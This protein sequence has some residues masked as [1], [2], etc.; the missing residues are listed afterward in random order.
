MSSAPAIARIRD[1]DNGASAAAEDTLPDEQILFS[2]PQGPAPPIWESSLKLQHTFSQLADRLASETVV[3]F[4]PLAQPVSVSDPP[5]FVSSALSNVGAILKSDVYTRFGPSSGAGRFCVNDNVLLLVIAAFDEM[6]LRTCSTNMYLAR[7]QKALAEANDASTFAALIDEAQTANDSGFSVALFLSVV[8][9]SSDGSIPLVLARMPEWWALLKKYE[10]VRECNVVDISI[11][12]STVVTMKTPGV[13]GQ[14]NA[15][16]L[17]RIVFHPLPT[18]THANVSCSPGTSALKVIAC[19]ATRSVA[20]ATRFNAKWS[21]HISDKSGRSF[22]TS[23]SGHGHNIASSLSLSP[24][25]GRNV[26]MVCGE[27]DGT[28]TI[29]SSAVLK[30]YDDWSYV[31]SK[32]SSLSA[33]AGLRS[34]L[35]ESCESHDPAAAFLL[36]TGSCASTA[37]AFSGE[38]LGP[39]LAICRATGA[40]MHWAPLL[41]NLIRA[42]SHLSGDVRA[43]CRAVAQRWLLNWRPVLQGDANAA[44]RDRLSDICD[45]VVDSLSTGSL[46][47]SKVL[48]SLFKLLENGTT[49]E[50]LRQAIGRSDS[51]CL[52]LSHG[53]ESLSSVPIS[54]AVTALYPLLASGDLLAPFSGGPHGLLSQ[55]KESILSTLRESV[56]THDKYSNRARVLELMGQLGD[57]SKCLVS[58][59]LPSSFWVT[60]AAETRSSISHPVAFNCLRSTRAGLR[61]SQSLGGTLV[62]SARMGDFDMRAACPWRIGACAADTIRYMEVTLLSEG[63]DKIVVGLS[64][65]QGCTSTFS[66]ATGTAHAIV[67]NDAESQFAVGCGDILG[68]GV[69]LEHFVF[70]TINGSIF[71]REPVQKSS[72]AESALSLFPFVFFSTK[73]TTSARFNFGEAP[74][75]H[76]HI[77][78]LAKGPMSWPT[79]SAS[80]YSAALAPDSPFFPSA[81]LACVGSSESVPLAVRGALLGGLER[82][83]DDQLMLL[84]ERLSSESDLG[85]ALLAAIITEFDCAE[86]DT[87]SLASRLINCITSAELTTRVVSTHGFHWG[88]HSDTVQI[89]GNVASLESE[90]TPHGFTFG[91]L[92]PYSDNVSF[93]VSFKQNVASDGVLP[94]IGGLYVGVSAV[95]TLDP[96]GWKHATPRQAWGIHKEL[97]EQLS[98]ASLAPRP[99][100]IPLFNGDSTVTVTVNRRKGT[101]AFDCDGEDLGV[102]FCGIPEAV[103]LYPFVQL[104]GDGS[105]A[106]GHSLKFDSLCMDTHLL[107]SGYISLLRALLVSIGSADTISK[108]LLT[109]AKAGRP[110]ILLSVLGASPDPRYCTHVHSDGS[111]ILTLSHRVSQ[112]VLRLVLPNGQHT[113]VEQHYLYPLDTF[114]ASKGP[115]VPAHGCSSGLAAVVRGAG[116]FINEWVSSSLCVAQLIGEESAERERIAS[117]ALLYLQSSVFSPPP[118]LGNLW[119]QNGSLLEAVLGPVAPPPHNSFCLNSSDDRVDFPAHYG[120]S[121]ALSPLS[122][123]AN[124]G[125][126]VVLGSNAISSDEHT[127]VRIILD[128]D[129]LGML[130]YRFSDLNDS[131]SVGLV[132][133]GFSTETRINSQPGAPLNIWAIPAIGTKA[134][135]QQNSLLPGLDTRYFN[136][137]DRI[138]LCVNRPRGTLELFVTPLQGAE[139]SLGVVFSD[140][141]PSGDLYPFVQLGSARASALFLPSSAVLPRP[142]SGESRNLKLL[143]RSLSDYVCDGCAR[144]LRSTLLSPPNWYRCNQCSCYDLCSACFSS[145]VHPGHT[146]THMKLVSALPSPLAFSTKIETGGQSAEVLALP[147]LLAKVIGQG[148]PLAPLQ[149]LGSGGGWSG[150]AWAV[151]RKAHAKAATVVQFRFKQ[152]VSARQPPS[153]TTPL[154]V[155]FGVGSWSD[156]S[157]LQSDAN[158]LEL[159]TRAWPA[160]SYPS[161]VSFD[162]S[163]ELSMSDNFEIRFNSTEVSLS[164]NGT[165][166]K[167]SEVEFGSLELS[168]FIVFSAAVDLVVELIDPCS[169]VLTGKVCERIGSIVRLSSGANSRWCDVREL[170]EPLAIVEA[171]AALTVGLRVYIIDDV[172]GFKECVVTDTS[173]LHDNVV[174]LD[175][176]CEEFRSAAGCVWVPSFVNTSHA[177]NV[178]S[179][180]RDEKARMRRFY[181][182]YAPEK[183]DDEIMVALQKFSAS[184]VGVDGMFSMLVKKYGPEPQIKICRPTPKRMANEASQLSTDL[185]K[186]LGQMLFAL[187]HNSEHFG[188]SEETLGALASSLLKIASSASPLSLVGASL[189]HPPTA[190]STAISNVVSS[191]AASLPIPSEDFVM[192]FVPST[193]AA[194]CRITFDPSISDDC[195][196]IG[197]EGPDGL[198]GLTAHRT[199]ESGR[200]RFVIRSADNAANVL[201][202]RY[203]GLSAKRG[204]LRSH[205][206]ISDALF[207]IEIV[208][209]ASVNGTVDLS[210]WSVD[211]HYGYGT[212]TGLVS[213]LERCMP[214]KGSISIKERATASSFSSTC[215]L[216]P[217]SRGA[218]NAR[219]HLLS[220]GDAR[221]RFVDI[222]VR[223]SLCD[224]FCIAAPPGA[225]QDLFN[226]ALAEARSGRFLS[227]LPRIAKHAWLATRDTDAILK[228]VIE[229]VQKHWRN[230]DLVRNLGAFSEDIGTPEGLELKSTVSRLLAP[231]FFHFDLLARNKVAM[232]TVLGAALD[233]FFSLGIPSQHIPLDEL[234]VLSRFGE[235]SGAKVSDRYY[236]KVTPSTFSEWRSVDPDTDA[237]ATSLDSGVVFTSLPQPLSAEGTYFE[238]VQPSFG[239]VVISLGSDGRYVS[240]DGVNMKRSRGCWK[241][242]GFVLPQA[243]DVLGCLVS[244]VGVVFSIN[245]HRYPLV[246]LKSEP[247]V[248]YVAVDRSDSSLAIFSTDQTVQHLPL[249]AQALHVAPLPLA[250]SVDD[251]SARTKLDKAAS[252]FVANAMLKVLPFVDRGAVESRARQTLLRL[253]DAVGDAFRRTVLAPLSPL[254]KGDR[255]L[256]PTVSVQW[257]KLFSPSARTQAEALRST[258]LA[259]L[260]SQLSKDNF[261]DVTPM[262]VTSLSMT[263]SAHTPVDAGGPYMAVWGLVSEEIMTTESQKPNFHRNPMFVLTDS[264]DRRVMVPNRQCVGFAHLYRFLGILMGHMVRA[265]TPMAL[266]FS[267]FVWKVLVG[268]NVTVCDYS[269]DVD[270]YLSVLVEDDSLLADAERASEVFSGFE[271]RL[272]EMPSDTIAARREV[273]AHCVIHQLDEQLLP[274]RE[275]MALVLGADRLPFM[276]WQDLER[277]VCGDPNPTFQ[278]VRD[279][280]TCTLPEPQQSMFWEALESFSPSEWGQFFSFCS[281]QRR[282]PLSRRIM[283]VPDA[284]SSLQHLPV[285]QTCFSQLRMPLYLSAD[286]MRDRLRKC[287]ASEEME[288]A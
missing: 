113:D 121:L 84:A 92:L 24:E 235:C 13:A 46:A 9:L 210:W 229:I 199:V 97:S 267:P 262:F 266:D 20:P 73:N 134:A 237:L 224:R 122:S 51:L 156:L 150:G 66:H 25:R 71:H 79:I 2:P 26:M 152:A 99:S 219:S 130:P 96:L 72:E 255:T 49:A 19:N 215:P 234:A 127:N 145:H 236:P 200:V 78:K 209:G 178:C 1:I 192:N 115:T 81:F 214:V 57:D 69:D 254:K 59:T 216:S 201:L 196:C 139:Q 246:R 110:D 252:R 169:D 6:R 223:P 189:L 212:A 67:F 165:T 124:E 287:I 247:S 28:V 211:G 8:L 101:I 7:I 89:S 90:D 232:P 93:S 288:L 17:S 175:D 191:E 265:K 100:G 272:S 230:A 198:Q 83:D 103:P 251:G 250:Q 179:P 258:V 180:F 52:I 238:V 86:I 38:D 244:T 61:L 22:V 172:L 112:Q 182:A 82:M 56:V 202:S 105:R 14:L 285:A 161:V 281:A 276:T 138:R 116:N 159:P 275:G 168:T 143:S 271:R 75:S 146:F 253:K 207:E 147:L 136:A 171:A 43:S 208:G 135:T 33:M 31:L 194:R 217:L 149:I 185:F 94:F 213:L 279:S 3:S 243:G 23:L 226:N 167:R 184:S 190:P 4:P 228:P 64:S 55:F 30:C 155:V 50:D 35:S 227:L 187:A 249:G 140:L 269:E 142:V 273:A 12:G 264:K 259:Q 125:P 151:F 108:W 133:E 131:Y 277:G 95:Q 45:L 218:A 37:S 176:G 27:L 160:G 5:A 63:Y 231:V 32:L 260:H 80:F 193:S 188:D 21:A 88:G 166:I 117:C 107:R 120:G 40:D 278:Q 206:L 148:V 48:T 268:D 225:L 129:W 10:S 270:S 256:I 102:V 118:S 18:V 68:C 177:E 62:E 263:E 74:F 77:E 106:F 222:C 257:F 203:F 126:F 274:M 15:P 111:T 186:T 58:S 91:R 280:I 42:V 76:T 44:V 141:P 245:A 174:T 163:R 119:A 65:P 242:F 54:W 98:Y 104:V 220:P 16:K 123:K 181:D 282:Y 233:A 157:P 283:V 240:F 239:R 36:S 248:A 114:I 197:I 261:F 183:T 195:G 137:A 109:E 205:K 241:P 286:H 70:F 162:S 204:V 128:C 144:S 170:R 221:V 41:T 29:E 153:C 47:P 164:V 158:F 39:T 53:F 284:H 11:S 154:R 87:L 173:A 60:L 34:L 85:G 132:S